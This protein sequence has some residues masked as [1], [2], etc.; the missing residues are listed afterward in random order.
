MSVLNDLASAQGRRDEVPN[1]ELARRLARDEDAERVQEDIQVLVSN[2]KNKNNAIRHDCIK[3][4]YEIG[5]EKPLLIEG[6]VDE[7][8]ALLMQRDNRMIWGGMTALGS[9]AALKPQEL[10]GHRDTLIQATEGGSAITQDWGIRVLAALCA[11][12]EAYARGLFPFLMTFLENCPAK[13]VPRHAES[14]LVGAI[15]RPHR[16]QLR[17]MLEGRRPQLSTS[18][19]KRV[20]KL[21]QR[22]AESSAD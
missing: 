14:I 13:D 17:Q 8:V 22:L 20:D 10:W 11:A 7:F 1:Q 3:V 5:A 19:G 4:L 9:I 21:I 18:Q 2:L 16:D 12:S 6:Y 15:N